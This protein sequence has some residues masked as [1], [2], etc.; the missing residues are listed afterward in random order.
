MLFSRAPGGWLVFCSMT[1]ELLPESAAE[2][3]PLRKVDL[4]LLDESSVYNPL[5][6]R[7]YCAVT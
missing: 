4:A 7:A 1:K 6:G 3:D 2:F 5:P